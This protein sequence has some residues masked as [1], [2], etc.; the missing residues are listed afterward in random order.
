M[1]AIAV[2]LLRP[3]SIM[4]IN[5]IR[6][7]RGSD[8]EEIAQLVN[9]AYRPVFSLAA[10]WTHELDFVSGNRTSPTQ[11]S[12]LLLDINSVILLGLVQKKIVACVHIHSVK[13]SS[14]IG[15]LAVNPTLQGK[16]IGK[17]ILT[18]AEYYSAENYG[19]T[20]CILE[21]IS[22]RVEL[23]EFYRRRGYK[24]SG[25]VK[26]YPL[27]AEVGIPKRNLNID[28]LEKIIAF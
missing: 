9:S 24:K 21:V 14:H 5:N 19:T 23:I 26:E 8:C 17:Q 12:K 2:S 27:F 1:L 13:D 20:R 28:V 4:I 11:I 15:M 6:E 18:I 10:G 7:A 25:L 22:Q 16:G 3:K